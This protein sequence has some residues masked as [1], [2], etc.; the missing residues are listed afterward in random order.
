MIINILS[1][2]TTTRNGITI[3]HINYISNLF[4]INLSVHS[5]E[6]TNK[7]KVIIIVKYLTLS[8]DAILGDPVK[9]KNESDFFASKVILSSK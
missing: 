2:T 5:W 7:H 3:K 8:T 6:V 1:N 4:I 9:S